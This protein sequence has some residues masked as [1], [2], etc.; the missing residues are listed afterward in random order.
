MWIGGGHLRASQDKNEVEQL[1]LLYTTTPQLLGVLAF[2]ASRYSCAMLLPRLILSHSLCRHIAPHPP[3][4]E[5]FVFIA[6]DCHDSLRP[7]CYLMASLSTEFN[8]LLLPNSQHLS[9]IS[10]EQESDRPS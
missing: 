2:S 7:Q 5:A 10:R 1:F 6:L 3:A 4:T 8:L 9:P